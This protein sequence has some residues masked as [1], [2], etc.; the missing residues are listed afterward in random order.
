MAQ[1]IAAPPPAGAQCLGIHLEGPFLA[2]DHPGMADPNGFEPLS[3]T[4]FQ[5]F[6]DAARGHIRMLTFAPEIDRRAMQTIPH[7]IR[8]G[9]VPAIGHSNA[10][11]E[12]VRQAVHLGLGHASHTFNAMRGFHHREPGVVG[13]VLYFEQVVAQ[14]IADGVHLHPATLALLWRLKGPQNVALVSDAA[15]PAALPEGRYP[16]NEQTI[17]VKDGACRRPDGTLAGSHTPL[18][19]GLRHLVNRVGIPLPEALPAVTATPARVL[20]RPHV[21][22]LAPGTQADIVLLDAK[23]QPTRTLIKGHEVFR[24]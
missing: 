8:A 4:A 22:H 20:S 21:G 17:V 13:A 1:V 11:F 10:T 14:A 3:W 18:D 24:H 12:Q 5:R 7:L 2:P 15:P 23:L 9:V 19:G 16:W 6:Q